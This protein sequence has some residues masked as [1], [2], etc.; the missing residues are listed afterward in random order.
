MGEMPRLDWTPHWRTINSNLIELV[1]LIPEER[2]QWAPREGEWTAPLI[3]THLILARYH[4]PIPEPSD[5][6]RIGQVP[7]TCQERSGLKDELRNSWSMIERFVSDGPRLDALYPSGATGPF[8]YTA[9]PERYDGHYIA[10]HRFAHDLH[11]R[12]TVIGYLAQL[13]VPLDGHRIRPL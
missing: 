8:S 6:V 10:Y 11:H 3:L 2:W 5:L 1:D 13:G 9:E 12:S 4:G 7:V